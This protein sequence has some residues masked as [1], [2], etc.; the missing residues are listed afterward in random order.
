MIE[1]IRGDER[2]YVMIA[3]VGRNAS[4]TP[5]LLCLAS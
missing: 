4:L 3:I 5:A 1:K 2:R